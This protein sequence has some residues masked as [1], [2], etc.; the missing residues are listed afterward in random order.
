MK[1]GQKE[2]VRFSSIRG[3]S[4][5][6]KGSPRSFPAHWHNAAEFTLA[7]KDGCRYK[8]A[9]KNVELS[10]GD[11]LFIWPREVHEILSVPAD[12]SCFIQFDPYMLENNLDL[13]SLERYFP[14]HRKISRAE[15]PELA[16]EIASLFLK[17]KE[18]G[19]TM[20]FFAETRCK[21]IVT[22]ILL[23]EGERILNAAGGN[24]QNIPGAPG[25]HIREAESF[26]EEHYTE[27]ISQA[28]VA[29]HVGLSPYYFSRLFREISGSSFP[30]YLTGIRIRA[31]IR[32]LSY[33]TYTITECAFRAGFQS[34][35]TF[36]KS[37][38]ELM[39][40]SPREF[41]RMHL[42]GKQ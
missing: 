32:L 37:F 5:T 2:I 34:T 29:S 30:E 1:T 14:D 9:G 31:A 13:L 19:E 22:D 40:C 36:N 24:L 39:G 27:N 17:I 8:I 23:L 35:T 18:E 7:L 12:G 6:E 21:K 42:S 11:I 41:C 3:V 25:S 33:G 10:K 4:F 38:R 20:S 28:E 26:M 16:D 15:E